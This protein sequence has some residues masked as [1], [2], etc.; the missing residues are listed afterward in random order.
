MRQAAAL[1]V[2]PLREQA[3]PKLSVRG[4]AKSY[5]NARGAVISA[6]AQ[7]LFRCVPT[8]EL[9]T[10]QRRDTTAP[11]APWLESTRRVRTI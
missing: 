4:V 3:G 9:G 8:V 1:R 10:A 7:P 2:V 5:R 11:L 6:G